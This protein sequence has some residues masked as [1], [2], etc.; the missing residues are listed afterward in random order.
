MI[1]QHHRHGLG[2]FAHGHRA[3]GG[4]GHEEVFVEDLPVH[5]ALASFLEYIQ[6]YDQIGQQQ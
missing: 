1:Q 4:D 6:T 5:N 2:I 3:K